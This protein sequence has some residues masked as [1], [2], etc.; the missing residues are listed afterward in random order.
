MEVVWRLWNVQDDDD[1][2]SNADLLH[3]KLYAYFVLF[4]I[5]TLETIMRWEFRI[6]IVKRWNAAEYKWAELWRLKKFQNF[7][8][9]IQM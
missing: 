8:T 3:I 9:V 7:A 5:Y 2:D 4:G 1:D 6:V